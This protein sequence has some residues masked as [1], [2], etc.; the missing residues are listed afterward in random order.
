MTEIKPKNYTR[1]LDQKQY[2]LGG[3]H[4][5]EINLT[6]RGPSRG[7]ALYVR[8]GLN[9]QIVETSNI[10]GI[11]EEPTD[12]I[13][14]ELKINNK[15]KMIISNIYLSPNCTQ[16]ENNNI[17]NFIRTFS[18]M[19]YDHHLILG[20]FNRKTINWD[21]VSSTSGDDCAF[22]EAV[23]DGF[24]TQH[25]LSPTRGRG[26]NDP[27]LIDLV[28][29]TDEQEIE[30]IDITAPL[31]KSDHAIIKVLYRSNP[32]ILPDKI[33]C[34]YSKADYQKFVNKM[35]INWIDQLNVDGIDQM[36]MHF[37]SRFNQAEEECVPRKVVKTGKKRFTYH[38]DRKTLAKRKK[39]YRLWKR[40]LISKDKQIYEEY[41][42]C[43]N[44]Y[45]RLTR[46]AIKSHEKEIAK[47]TKCNNKVF[48]RYINS[49]IKS[50]PAIPELYTSSNTTKM[51]SDDKEKANILANFFSSV[52]K[53]EPNWTWVMNKDAKPEINHEFRLKIT[54]DV[55]TKRLN[56]LN[57]NKSPGPDRLHPR[58]LKEAASVLINPLYIIFKCSISRGKI[59][60]AWKI[61]TVAAIY[62][63]KGNRHAAENY[64]P[65]T[66]TSIACK[67]LESIV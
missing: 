65:I 34:D 35:D 42:R 32:E 66:L 40:Y 62:K 54:K 20:D 45:R 64:R 43:R 57:I 33:T 16:Q 52:Y 46:K 24:L 49:K 5:E 63:N 1:V 44:Q 22:I 27:S 60:K 28:F 7:V 8:N 4:F 39:K 26:T 51:T 36:W 2:N 18:K 50:R 21:T 6:V 67:I 55:I 61:G 15:E 25:I 41:C 17:N 12:V 59:P 11:N 31:G 3:Y 9:Y 13:S 14:V 10:V 37:V 48:W 19:K 30:N 38:L 53:K 58:I 47:N 56:N 29:S 23:R